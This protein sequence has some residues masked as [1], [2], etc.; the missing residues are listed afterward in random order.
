MPLGLE[1]TKAARRLLSYFSRVVQKSNMLR[2]LNGLH[3]PFEGH[4][5]TS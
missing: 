5:K 4:G 2:Y 3:E 1:G